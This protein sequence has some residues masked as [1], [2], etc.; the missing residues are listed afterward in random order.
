MQLPLLGNACFVYCVESQ[1]CQL[2]DF[3]ARFSN[4]SDPPS[5]FFLK[6]RLAT[7]LAT[8]WT[9]LS[10]SLWLRVS[11][12]HFRTRARSCFHSVHTPPS[13]SLSLCSVQRA[14]DRSSTFSSN[15]WCCFSNFTC[16]YSWKHGTGIVFA[17]VMCIWFFCRLTSWKG[18]LVM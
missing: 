13:L 11:R 3:V 14:A 1:C 15:R 5:D 2:S 12:W 16:K 7:N 6:K 8:S 17:Y 4:F 9:N 10:K 18:E